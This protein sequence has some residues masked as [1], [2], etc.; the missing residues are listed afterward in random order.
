[1]T[2]VFSRED[3]FITSLVLDQQEKQVVWSGDGLGF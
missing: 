2:V 1:M 3:G